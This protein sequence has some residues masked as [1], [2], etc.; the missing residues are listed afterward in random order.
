MT[1]RARV[2]LALAALAAVSV[3]AVSWLGYRATVHRLNAESDAGLI[4]Y[5]NRLADPD[6]RLASILCGRINGFDDADDGGVLPDL[7]GASVQ[8]LAPPSGTASPAGNGTRVVTSGLALR[9]ETVKGQ[10]YRVLSV[11]LADG[12]TIRIARSRAS[13][14]RVLRSLSGR[15]VAVGVTAIGLAALAGWLIARQ[16]TRPVVRLTGAAEE[17]AATGRLDIPV[18]GGGRDEIGRLSA[19]FAAMLAALRSSREQQHS[20]VQD[21]GHELRTPL[22]SLTANVETLLRHRN[23]D[24]DLRDRILADVDSE[25][26]ELADLVD[27]LVA[28]ATDRHDAE[29]ERPVAVLELT[30]Q[31]CERA[32]RRTGREIV[33]DAEPWT[34]VAPP[35]LLL[36]AIGNLLDN[37]AKFSS[38]GTP[39]ELTVRP[40]S[41]RVRDHGPG[42]DPAD[43]P[44]VFDRF[45]RSVAAR[46]LPGSGL[47]LA[48]VR[49][50]AERAGGTATATNDPG[51]GAV[52]TI[53]LPVSAAAPEQP[54][55]APA[56][57][58]T[59]F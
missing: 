13:T 10:R 46:S 29:P 59:D 28:L 2:A 41:I 8:C 22:T 43:L 27:E 32:E 26:R 18:P 3:V 15:Y 42:I 35:D 30:E 20:L 33:V 37:A 4:S 34:A 31:A 7:P 21:A 49:D 56:D 44:H 55:P 45:Y 57:S 54:D 1:L 48:I 19:S 52:L 40:G 58:L 47:G 11:P 25:L 38:D 39:I 36:R 17:I 9:T 5:A 16:A 24:G 53:E 51:G 12:R 50:V 6:G 23:L 14:E